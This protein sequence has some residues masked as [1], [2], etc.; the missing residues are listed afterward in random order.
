M[1]PIFRDDEFRTVLLTFVDTHPRLD[2][3]GPGFVGAGSDDRPVATSDHGN[4]FSPQIGVRLLLH[5]GKKGV[6]ITVD[7]R[8]SAGHSHF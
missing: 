5:G 4:R 2:A 6:L 1:A 8:A 3:S 7:D